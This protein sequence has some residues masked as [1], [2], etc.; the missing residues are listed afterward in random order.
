MH[1]GLLPSTIWQMDVTHNA[2]F[3]NLKYV[4]MIIDNCSSL[5]YALA[6]SEENGVN[7][8]KIIKSAM[9]VS[10]LLWTLTTDNGPAYASLQFSDFL[11][12]WKISHTTVER[13]NR[14]HKELLARTILIEARSSS[15]LFHM[16]IL[17]FDDKRLSPAYKHWTS[18]PMNTLLLLVKWRDTTSLQWQLLPP[19]PVGEGMLVSFLRLT[20][21]H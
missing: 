7:V 14:V 6:L 13:T 3:G 19:Q 8:S 2:T 12:S 17:S 11:G 10:G 9:V 4:R 21:W 1:R 20:Q 18:L 16:N 5:A 15:G